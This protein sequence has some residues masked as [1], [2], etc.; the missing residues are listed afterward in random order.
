MVLQICDSKQTAN[1]V[2]SSQLPFRV[3]E[4]QILEV[5]VLASGITATIDGLPVAVRTT[6]GSLSGVKLSAGKSVLIV[7][8]IFVTPL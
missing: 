8:D 1:I 6:S 2:V 3:G 4:W 7:D 5:T